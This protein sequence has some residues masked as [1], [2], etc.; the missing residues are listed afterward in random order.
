MSE[1]FNCKQAYG[2]IYLS[3]QKSRD[4]IIIERLD[5]FYKNR[6]DISQQCHI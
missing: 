5:D 4:W 6:Y 3:V 2:V 1:Q